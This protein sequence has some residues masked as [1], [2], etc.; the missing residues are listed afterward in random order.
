MVEFLASVQKALVPLVLTVG[1]YPALEAIGVE[2]PAEYAEAVAAGA[3]SS[4]FVWLF[5]NGKLGL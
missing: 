1:I 3:V 5:P 2:L 4:F